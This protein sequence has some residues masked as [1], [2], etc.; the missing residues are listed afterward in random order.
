MDYA[1][2]M[3]GVANSIK[4]KTGQ[5]LKVKIGI[6]SG[7]VVAGVVG[8]TKP[9]FSLIGDTVNKTSRVC[10]KCPAKSI[11]IS[12]ETHKQLEMYSNNFQFDGMEVFMKG[13][14]DEIVY[15]VFKRKAVR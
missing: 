5:K 11:L 15:K 4:L 7:E 8:E 13:I 2:E 12:K 6:H 10:S 14:G 9:Q 1:F 3:L